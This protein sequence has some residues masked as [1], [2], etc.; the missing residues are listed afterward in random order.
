MSVITAKGLTPIKGPKPRVAVTMGDPAGIGPEVLLKALRS[1]RVRRVASPVVVGDRRA[2]EVIAAKTGIPLP[3]TLEIISPAGKPP[4]LG[5]LR[6]GF[7]PLPLARE[8]P[9]YIE[10]AV[11]LVTSG[12][13]EAVVTAPINKGA[14]KKAGFSF[15]GHT[16]FLAHLTGAKDFVMMLGGKNLKVTLVTIHEPLKN[17]PSL[18]TKERILKTI[19]VTDRAF[20]L[21]FG[22]ER[23]RIG[24]LGFNPHAGEGGLFGDEE[25]R[26][27]APAIKS[28]RRSGIEAIGPVVPDTA[29]IRSVRG[30]FDVLVCMYH[31]QGLGPL[32]LLHFDD[33]INATLGLPV[34]RTSVD[35]GT[36]YDLAW[37]GTA[38]PASMV[39][40][41]ETAALMAL[42][43]RDHG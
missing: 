16:E 32:K 36:A 23:P 14:L 26:I 25:G 15:P 6:P 34:I 21:F 40:A 38:S 20:R 27:I 2:L 9:R 42:S 33:G 22:M 30:E 17:V 11:R 5:T 19:E 37:Q 41:I 35:H 31:D 4:P 1:A 12:D 18:I 13:S 3:R 43:A 28:A 39:S 7:L 8:V 10:E 24:V 29:F